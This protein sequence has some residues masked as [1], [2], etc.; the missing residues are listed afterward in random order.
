MEPTTVHSTFVI[1]KHYPTQPERVFAALSTPAVKRRWFAEGPGHDAEEFELDFRVGG[2]ERQSYR[3][4]EATPFPGALISN[5][6]SILDIVPGQRIVS[7]STMSFGGRRISCSLITFELVPNGAG[8]DLIFTHQ[9]A[10]FE[11]ADGPEMREMG[12]KTLFDQLGKQ[13]AIEA[14]HR[15]AAES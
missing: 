12:W 5:D 13:L 6:G 8:T 14:G 4:G 7:V 15:A 1:E 11:G 10:F 2:I 3:L 9:G